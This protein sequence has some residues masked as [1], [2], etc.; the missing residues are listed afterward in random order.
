MKA[1]TMRPFHRAWIVGIRC[2]SNSDALLLEAIMKSH[3]IKF[4]DVDRDTVSVA[5]VDLETY[6]VE[7]RIETYIHGLKR[8]LE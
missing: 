5:L 3:G 7:K 4:T 1:E 2:S 8:L 6:S